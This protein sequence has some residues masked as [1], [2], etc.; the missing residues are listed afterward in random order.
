MV[1][2]LIN[3]L[4]A[5]LMGGATLSF[6]FTATDAG[7]AAVSMDGEIVTYGENYRMETEH[8]LVVSDGTVIGIYQKGADEIILQPVG[9]GADIMANPFAV[10]KDGN[11][12]NYEVTAQGK[13][14]KGLP[15]KV[16]LKARNG[17]VYTIVIGE[18]S[19]SEN[20][21][22]ALFTID[23]ENYPTAIVTDLR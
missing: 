9:I 13:D 1:N 3:T 19:A 2:G 8:A 7:G 11:S 14:A 5:F 12:A 23:P 18:Y 16:I 17:A 15:E 22:A 10:L 21:N 20:S 4:V 6:S